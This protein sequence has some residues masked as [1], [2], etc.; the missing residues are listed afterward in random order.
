MR[1]IDEIDHSQLRADAPEYTPA[2]DGEKI[3][4]PCTRDQYGTYCVLPVEGGR[5]GE[6]EIQPPPPQDSFGQLSVTRT[7]GPSWK[8]SCCK[9]RFALETDQPSAT[10]STGRMATLSTLY[11]SVSPSR[12]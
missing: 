7:P 3:S 11:I 2:L 4:Q 10:S 12:C 1:E 8:P 9:T 6:Q 5:G